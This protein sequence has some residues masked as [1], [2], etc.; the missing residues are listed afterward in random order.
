[1]V[2][3]AIEL[4]GKSQDLGRT[5]VDAETASLAAVPI[6]KN[7]APEFLRSDWDVRHPDLTGRGGFPQLKGTNCPIS[8]FRTTTAAFYAPF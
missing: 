4:V 3:V 5:K 7:P 8:R 1:V 6:D 2:T